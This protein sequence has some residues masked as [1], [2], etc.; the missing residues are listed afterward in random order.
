MAVKDTK[1]YQKMKSKNWLGK[2][3]MEEN[4]KKTLYYK[5]KNYFHSKNLGF[6]LEVV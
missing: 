5:V 6:F 1:I 4:E 3:K 2:K